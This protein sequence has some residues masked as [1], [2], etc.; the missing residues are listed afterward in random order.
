MSVCVRVYKQIEVRGDHLEV[1]L[2]AISRFLSFY[3]DLGI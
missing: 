2:Q 1:E 3:A